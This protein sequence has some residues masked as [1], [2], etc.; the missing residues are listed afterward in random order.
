M[1]EQPDAVPEKGGHQVYHY[2]IKEARPDALL[3]DAGSHHGDVLLGGYRFRLPHGAFDT[4]RNELER[5]SCVDPFLRD[6][7]GD[8]ESGYAQGRS[9][10]PPARDVERPAS[11]HGR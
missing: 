11:R 8:D 4:V 6:R 5:R 9:A 10:T 2:L 3:Y 1:L 7:V